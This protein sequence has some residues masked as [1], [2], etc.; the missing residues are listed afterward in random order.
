MKHNFT[1]D[2]STEGLLK[3]KR[4]IIVHTSQSLVHN[5][6]IEVVSS[7]FHITIEEDTLSDAEATN[8]EVDKAPPALEDGG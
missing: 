3:V 5:E 2:I 7:S 6:H 8:E 4:R 1:L